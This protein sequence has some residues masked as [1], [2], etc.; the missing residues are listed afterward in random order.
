M[1]T[2]NNN[3]NNNNNEDIDNDELQQQ[4]NEE[5]QQQQP[6]VSTFNEQQRQ[7]RDS[8]SGLSTTTDG[9]VFNLH[10]PHGPVD[11]DR[12]T[13]GVECVV[14]E[15]DFVCK[16]HECCPS[17]PTHDEAGN[18]DCIIYTRFSSLDLNSQEYANKLQIEPLQ[19]I[20]IVSPK[21]IKKIE[22]I[23]IKIVS[24]SSNS[25]SSSIQVIVSTITTVVMAK[26]MHPLSPIRCGGINNQKQPKLEV[27]SPALLFREF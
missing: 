11:N 7:I 21:T 24:S 26:I 4:D 25:S 16:I 1:S 23:L 2:N 5:Q 6:Q 12:V 13:T 22:P 14:E 27:L 19:S 20:S 8:S 10:D 3:N 9:L 15:V 18:Q 17:T